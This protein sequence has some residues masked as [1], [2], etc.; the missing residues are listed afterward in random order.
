MWLRF[1]HGPWLASLKKM[2]SW[3]DLRTLLLDSSL[4]PSLMQA[5]V[6]LVVFQST[7]A[8][9]CQHHKPVAFSRWQLSWRFSTKAQ[10]RCSSMCLVVMAMLR[11]DERWCAWTGREVAPGKLEKREA[12]FCFKCWLFCVTWATVYYSC[13]TGEEGSRWVMHPDEWLC[14]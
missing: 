13:C 7:H 12:L 4:I 11:N 5:G 8:P 3:V 1:R 2:K 6:M 14:S 10:Y 9:I